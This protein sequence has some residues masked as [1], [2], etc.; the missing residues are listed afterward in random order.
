MMNTAKR[1][2]LN[3][4]VLVYISDLV[5]SCPDWRFGQILS[6]LDILKRDEDSQLCDPFYEEPD[7]T[8][9][10]V[11]AAYEKIMGGK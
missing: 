2:A 7:E 1:Q 3:R 10:R 9:G 5:Q 4:A 6:N 11:K 8:L